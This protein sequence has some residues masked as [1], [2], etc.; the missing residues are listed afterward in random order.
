MSVLDI[1][2]LE[3]SRSDGDPGSW[4]PVADPDTPEQ[5]DFYLMANLDEEASTQW[6]FKIGAHI[7]KYLKLP[8]AWHY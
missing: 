1:H 4:P 3:I 6:R 5:Q 8:G 7:A 2:E